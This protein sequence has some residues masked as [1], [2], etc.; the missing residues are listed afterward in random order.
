MSAPANSSQGL[1]LAGGVDLKKVPES[2]ILPR[3]V[4]GEAALL[5][6]HRDECFVTK[7][8]AFVAQVPS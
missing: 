5:V 4:G 1:D 6:R 8:A 3:Q 2:G 7:Q